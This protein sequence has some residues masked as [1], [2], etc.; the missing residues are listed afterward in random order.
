[1]SPMDVMISMNLAI[2]LFKTLMLLIILVLSKELA[3]ARPQT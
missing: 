3:K 1:M 2:L